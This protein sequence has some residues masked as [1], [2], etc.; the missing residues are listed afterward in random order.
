MLTRTP[1]QHRRRQFAHALVAQPV[2]AIRREGQTGL[3]DGAQFA[4]DSQ[5]LRLVRGHHGPP[6]LGA[7]TAHVESRSSSPAGPVLASAMK[8]GPSL[9]SMPA[10]TKV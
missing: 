4:R 5:P 7:A 1:R 2:E 10:T 8:P 6:G 3:G 9:K